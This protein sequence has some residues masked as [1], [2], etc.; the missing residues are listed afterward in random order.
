[1]KNI[2][3]ELFFGN[4]CPSED[5]N[6][7]HKLAVELT[8]EQD[9]FKLMLNENECELFDSYLESEFHFNAETARESFKYGFK[10]GVRL[11]SEAL[12]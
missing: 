6:L 1:M 5:Y 12:K 7:N 4:I 3:D 8:K 11:F 9:D 10:L 2:L